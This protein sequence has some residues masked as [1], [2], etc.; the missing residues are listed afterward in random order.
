[1]AVPGLLWLALA[2]LRA[3]GG[4]VE[5]GSFAP[6]VT[7]SAE[8]E[9]LT[10]ITFEEK[11]VKPVNATGLSSYM[12][13]VLFHHEKNPWP[14]GFDAFRGA[15]KRLENSVRVRDITLYRT[16]RF[17]MVDCT[18]QGELCERYT[19]FYPRINCFRSGY[20]LP[21]RRSW[22]EDSL[23]YWVGRA[24][25]PAFMMVDS[26][27]QWLTQKSQPIPCFI[28]VSEVVD[29]EL[30]A[31]WE[32]LAMEFIEFRNFHVAWDGDSW[33]GFPGPRPFVHVVG[34]KDLNLSPAPF[35][36]VKDKELI[37]AWIAISSVPVLGN[38]NWY[39]SWEL[40]PQDWTVVA[41]R[42]YDNETAVNAFKQRA[43]VLRATLRYTFC[44]MDISTE[45]GNDFARRAPRTA[46]LT[47]VWQGEFNRA[48]VCAGYSPRN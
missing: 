17:F 16:V 40:V 26:Y 37:R 32:E 20:M 9:N 45:G 41:L 4:P 13:L 27:E 19:D 12:A 24:V 42:H 23:T 22:H 21:F 18:N 38:L 1:M 15:K 7:Q 5:I 43:E 3:R 14:Q 28:L 2:V 11:V 35:E 29:T 44:A 30:I 33:F 46:D 39:Y 48:Q 25:R 10:A 8:M 31:I 6:A 34:S 36:L 47:W